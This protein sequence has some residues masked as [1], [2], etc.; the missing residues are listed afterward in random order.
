MKLFDI[1]TIIFFTAIVLFIISSIIAIKSS[2]EKRLKNWHCI[3]VLICIVPIVGSMIFLNS[4][5]NDE[6]MFPIKAIVFSDKSRAIVCEAMV[7]ETR[8]LNVTYAFDNHNP[9]PDTARILSIVKHFINADINEF[10]I[11][12]NTDELNLLLY[13]NGKADSSSM[14][15]K[16]FQQYVDSISNF[17]DK[18][19]TSI[20]NMLSKELKEYL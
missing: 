1:A 17:D 5:N 2:V 19:L 9:M 3:F 14:I 16:T 4:S 12:F 20:E 13:K 6:Q 8:Y 18:E 10:S 7:G 15:S 11:I